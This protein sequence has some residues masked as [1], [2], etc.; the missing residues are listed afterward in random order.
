MDPK[1][2]P[3]RTLRRN[4]KAAPLLG[5]G[6]PSPTRTTQEPHR[7]DSKTAP[8]LGEL[9]GEGPYRDPAIA[10]RRFPNNTFTRELG[11]E[12]PYRDPGIREK[13]FQNNHFTRE[14]GGEGPYRDPGLRQKRFQ[15]N[16]FTRGAKWRGTIQQHRNHTGEVPKQTPYWSQGMSPP[17]N[18][19]G[20]TQHR[21]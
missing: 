3:R 13:R 7:R 15:N 11:G 6:C 12:G 10:L 18:H 21:R 1:K 17:R 5:R 14:L 16:P 2:A 9:G 19:A 4:P 20:A 8:L